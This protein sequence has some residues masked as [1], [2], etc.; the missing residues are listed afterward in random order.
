[1]AGDYADPTQGDP[2]GPLRY[3]P[4]PPRLLDSPAVE[5]FLPWAQQ[6]GYWAILGVLMAAG[7][8]FPIPEDIPLLTAGWLCHQGALELPQTIAIGL[9]GVMF[10]DSLIF[11]VGR[12]LGASVLHRPFI[13][14]HYT[15]ARRARVERYFEKYGERTVF[16]GRFAAGVR[17][18]IFLSAGISGVSFR[19]FFLYDGAA[20]LASV[21]LLVLL[22]WY[23]GERIDQLLGYIATAKQ[24]IG[25][26]L[27]VA[28]P[29]AIAWWL[30][31]RRIARAAAPPPAASPPTD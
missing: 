8:G 17:A 15:A 5:S 23:F 22:A 26:A 14:R 4:R 6:Y 28:A 3:G 27:L 2:G 31:R 24:I 29:F 16:F 21:P 11:L 25:I 9:F 1:M 13:A 12:K 20:A 19:K 7:F 10:G 18:W 30:R